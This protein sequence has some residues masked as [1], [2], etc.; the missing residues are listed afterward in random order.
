MKDDNNY[1]GDRNGKM[2]I[3]G[4]V[5]NNNGGGGIGIGLFKQ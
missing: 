3:F 1:D 4:G 2:D 5:N